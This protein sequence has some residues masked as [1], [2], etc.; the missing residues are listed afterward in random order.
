MKLENG[1]P[2]NTEGR[3]EKEIRVYDFLD[4]LGVEYQRVDHEAAMTMEAC[5]EIDRTLGDGTAICKNLFLCNRQETDFYLLLMPGDKPFKTKNL[6]AQIGSAR[7][8]FAKPEYMEKYLDITPGSVS[9]MGLMNDKENAVTLLVDEDVLKGEYVGC[10]PCVNTSSLKIKTT[11]VFDKFL[12][13]DHCRRL[14]LFFQIYLP[15]ENRF[16]YRMLI[17]ALAKHYR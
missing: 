3:L 15:K 6:S 2:E 10:H 7:L 4:K 12:K 14:S 8:S 16:F 13:A 1:R 11:D 5:E 17:F 9:V